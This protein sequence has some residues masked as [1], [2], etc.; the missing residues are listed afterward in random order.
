MKFGRA[1]L[2]DR[3]GNEIGIGSYVEV[4]GSRATGRIFEAELPPGLIG[5]RLLG[6]AAGRL[7]DRKTWG[8]AIAPLLLG[9]WRC[10]W[11]R[12]T[13]KPDNRTVV[14]RL[15]AELEAEAA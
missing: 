8:I 7:P 5:V 4:D 12:R 13:A 2:K 10:S 3:D 11:V 1:R 6:T 9:A 14:E 15:L